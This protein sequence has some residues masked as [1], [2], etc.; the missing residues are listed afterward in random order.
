MTVWV[1][2]GG[3]RGRRE[4]RFFDRSLIGIGWPELGDLST[5][6]DRAELKAAYRMAFPGSSEGHV[7][8][9]VGQLWSFAHAMHVGDVV[10]VPRKQRPD[11]AI[12]EIRGECRF[13]G[14]YGPDIAHVR[15]V[16]WVVTDVPRAAFDE[17]LRF[18]FGGSMTISSVP[19]RDAERRVKAVAWFRPDVGSRPG[20]TVR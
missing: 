13:S 17:D 20:S 5:Y 6:A 14:A 9:Q 18:S 7:R 2:K 4:E 8:T 1:V 15:D 12:G 3:I 16:A 19:R 10:V 11:V